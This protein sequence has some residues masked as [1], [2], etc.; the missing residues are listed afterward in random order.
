VRM[1]GTNLEP[2]G[3]NLLFYHSAVGMARDSAKAHNQDAQEACKAYPRAKP[4]MI[5]A[6]PIV[7]LPIAPQH[8]WLF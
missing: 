6:M 5:C 3:V 4:K 1:R 8:R 7:S 2:R